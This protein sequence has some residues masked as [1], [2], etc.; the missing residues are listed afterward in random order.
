MIYW[1]IR[2]VNNYRQYIILSILILF[3]L[4]LLSLNEAKSITNL[5]RASFLVYGLIN[6]LKS[7]FDEFVYNKYEIK[8]LREEN[9]Q[10][11]KELSELRAFIREKEELESLLEFKKANPINF[12]TSRI[13]LKTS[14]IDGDKFII[15][16]GSVDGVKLNSIV[17]NSKGLLGYVSDLSKSYSLVQTIMN[18]NT[19]ISVKNLRTNCYGI[20][21]WDGKKFKIYYVN[22]SDDVK[23]GDIFVVS[24][25]STQFPDGIPVVRVKSASK[26]GESL[27]Y[28]IVAEDIADLKNTKYCL[29]LN[30][31]LQK[32]KL[33]FVTQSE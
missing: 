27:F 25:Y 17:F 5:R 28:D 15:D 14:H 32:E 29:L 16:K 20:L 7:P 26:S 11:V 22:K 24:E 2:F 31:N 13:L 10:L 30:Q 4:L 23:D 9:A 1:L 12:L 33:R 8:R 3:S 21:F 6:Y 19:R 18:L